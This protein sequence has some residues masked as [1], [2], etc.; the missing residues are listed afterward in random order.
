MTKNLFF[1]FKG[2][3]PEEA[4]TEVI[5]TI[6]SRNSEVEVAVIATDTKVVVT[7]TV[8]RTSEEK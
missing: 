7:N 5:K 6:H 1:F 2:K 4:C 8:K 3:L